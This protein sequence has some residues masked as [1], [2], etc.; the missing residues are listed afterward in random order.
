MYPGYLDW[1]YCR[2]KFPV[3][4]NQ[5]LASYA[6]SAS[7]RGPRP[8]LR[9]QPIRRSGFLPIALLAAASAVRPACAQSTIP[10]ETQPAHALPSKMTTFSRLLTSAPQI[11]VRDVTV[12]RG[13]TSVE[14]HIEA[15]GPVTPVGKVLTDPERIVID[16]PDVGY[17]TSSRLPVDT[18]DVQGVRVALFHVDP[19]ITRVVVD[20]AHPRE[21]RLLTA[22][23]TVI[24]SIDTSTRPAAAAIVPA[25]AMSSA[26]PAA[27][28]VEQ[29]AVSTP[30]SEVR[31]TQAEAPA[32]PS[33]VAAAPAVLEPALE[34]Q[35]KLEP[36]L[37]RGGDSVET[38]SR[39]ANFSGSA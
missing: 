15:S 17:A 10:A 7:A 39:G 30:K 38:G 35:A 32:H 11:V 18:G 16:L 29:P 21:Y 36:P 12:L 22:G 23:S 28:P 6:E 26:P 9:I 5:A 34:S 14:V 20:L 19:P 3:K 27:M 31:K 13:K 37:S 2:S 24:L 33:E 25:M 8:T 1:F 4:L